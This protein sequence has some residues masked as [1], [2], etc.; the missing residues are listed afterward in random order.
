M[1]AA[2]TSTPAFLDPVATATL[3]GGSL[4]GDGTKAE[5]RQQ[6]AASGRW[7]SSSDGD[8]GAVG[9]HHVGESAGGGPDADERPDDVLVDPI[10]GLG[11][12]RAWNEAFRSEESRHARYR[13][14]VTVMV[15]ELDGL[16]SLASRFG[17]ETADRLIPPV[18]AVMQ[19]S[20]RA[21]DVLARTGHTRFLALLPETD[22]ISATNYVER[23][24]SACD[25]WLAAGGVDVR[26]AVG[27]AQP[28][29]GAHLSD[30]LRLADAR[31]NA[32]RRRQ[33]FRIAT[34]IVAADSPKVGGPA[35]GDV[36]PSGLEG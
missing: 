11:S 36:Q 15:A 18:G 1:S 3:P 16:D 28:P 8:P 6:T 35:V 34:P 13:R 25:M 4:P 10:T 9:A 12:R 5:P 17:Q 7:A 2:A 27:W 32:D 14:P 19:R 26:L 24:R 21:A 31:M 29:V 20:A 33:D 30:A 22:E 23:V